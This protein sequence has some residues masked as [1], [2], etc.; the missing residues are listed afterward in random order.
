MSPH[1][2]AR[3][4]KVVLSKTGFFRLVSA[5]FIALAVPLLAI[6]MRGLLGFLLLI[7][8]AVLAGLAERS[9]GRVLRAI[10]RGITF[11]R[12][13][14]LFAVWYSI[15]VWLN[16]LLRGNGLADWR[17]M[18]G[19]VMLLIALAF[20]LG[21]SR[22]EAAF[23]IFQIGLAVA[24]GVQAIFT[25]RELSSAAGIAR[26]MWLEWQGAWEFGNQGAYAAW[27]MLLPVLIWRALVERGVLRLLLLAAALLTGAAASIGSFATPLM[28][29]A[30]GGG[31]IISLVL[32]LPVQRRQRP[33]GAILAVA[34][35]VMGML[36]YHYTHENPLFAA[37]YYRIENFLADPQG[38]GYT[39]HERAG[40]RWL[41]ADISL[42]SFLSEPLF[43]MGGGSIRY[44]P[45]VGGHSSVFDSLGAYG[46]LGGGGALV[47]L[48]LTLLIVA[49][50]RFFTDRNWETLLALTSVILLLVSGVANPYGDGFPLYLVLMMARP[51]SLATAQESLGQPE[52]PSFYPGN[53]N[54]TRSSVFDRAHIEVSR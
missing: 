7:Y 53:T 48:L 47:G 45:Y 44:S 3:V 54:I 6:A 50:R 51:F 25:F 28:L 14:V 15:G 9:F 38:G 20:A 39:S 36:F 33:K 30:I 40:S 23:R 27:I 16:I 17:L 8:L 1:L 24:L 12:W 21:F 5:A 18:M 26:E 32:I 2:E 13:L 22:D 11:N 31:A 4:A 49:A 34:I 35:L 46:L 52:A 42:N 10:N 29:L 41:L 37:S 43:G 19:P